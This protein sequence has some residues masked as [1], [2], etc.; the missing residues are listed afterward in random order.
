MCWSP[1]RKSGL[2]SASSLSYEDAVCKFP[3]QMQI[4]LSAFKRKSHFAD[5]VRVHLHVCVCVRV[6][7]RERETELLN[8]HSAT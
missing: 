3:L 5:V 6:R 7:E 2:S 1:L 8:T 4:T